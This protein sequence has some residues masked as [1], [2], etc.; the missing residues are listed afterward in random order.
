MM[1]AIPSAIPTAVPT[2]APAPHDAAAVRE[3]RRLVFS[4]LAV[5]AALLLGMA[6]WLALAPLSGAVVAAGVVKV[7][8]ERKVVQHQEGGTVARIL[9]RNGDSVQAGQTLV[10]LQDVQLDA[11]LELVRLQLDAEQLR[12]A[13]LQAERQLLG[14]VE[15]PPAQRARQAEPRMAELVRRELD[16]FKLRRA[17]L[18][19]QLALLQTQVGA[20]R[21]EIA[22]R[23]A[24]SSAESDALQLQHEE[25]RANELLVEQGF[26]A[27][28]RLLAL[29]RG[30]AESDAR[31]G[32]NQA[33][34]AQAQQR[35]ADT[36]LRGL[37]LRND[38]VQQ[39]ERELK[40]STAKLF[41]LQQRLRPSQDA[42]DRQR[43]AA[44]VAGVVVDLK[45]ST[46]GGS[47]GPRE[48]LMDIVPLNPTLVVEAR[49]RPEDIAH[50]R[51][52]AAAEVR[53]TAFQQRSTPTVAGTLVYLSADRLIDPTTRA[54]YYT[55]QVRVDPAALARLLPLQLQAGMPAE[56]YLQTAARTPLAYWLDPV[57]GAVRRGMREP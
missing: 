12:Q 50:A 22:A 31:R 24:Q 3:L 53:L 41:D 57:L 56:V 52:G 36:T 47:I 44:P 32:S 54:G 34:L 16:F 42:V 14:T 6:A 13:R 26:I 46:E 51:P 8:T 43:I 9:V 7:D 20:T 21:Q 39:A 55:A 27:K 49:V 45:L 4:G 15:L 40:D 19:S 30:V 2:A 23:G 11:A 29:Q 5:I 18:D 10:E 25:L 48:R 37:N 38:Y 1:S 33:E 28:T 35:V 17:T